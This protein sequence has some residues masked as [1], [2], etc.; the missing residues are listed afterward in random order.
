M[1]ATHALAEL[2]KQDVPDSVSQG[3]RRPVLPLRPRVPDP[4]AV[5][6]ARAGLG[7]DA[8]WRE[9]AMET[10]VARKPLDLD[11]Y[12]D[13]L[14]SLLGKTRER[15]ARH[16]QQGAQRA[17]ADR[18]PGGGEPADP[19]RHAPWCAKRGWRSRSFSGRRDVIEE[20]CRELDLDLGDTVVIDPEHDPRFEAYVQEY[21][22]LRQRKGETLDGARIAMRNAERL[23]R[24]DGADGR[25]RRHDLRDRPA[26]ARDD[27]SVRADRGAQA[28]ARPGSAASTS[29]SPGT[30]CTSSPTPR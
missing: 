15:H 14:E 8:P 29:C 25:R 4:Q 24:D 7:G 3:L 18:L 6:F 1:A 26:A 19:A 2:A 30:R 9:A 20:E 28:G 21:Y 5:R 16:H 10:G 23:R 11:E 22:R 27:P 13:R 17:E 12:R